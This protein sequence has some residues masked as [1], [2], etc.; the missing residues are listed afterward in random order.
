MDHDDIVGSFLD[1]AVDDRVDVGPASNAIM[2]PA[3]PA[4]FT[5]N[6]P[7]IERTDELRRI[8]GSPELDEGSRWIVVRDGLVVAE[9][10]YPDLTGIACPSAGA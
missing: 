8:A 2:E 1:C 5:V 7:W 9:V 6:L 3:P 10:D 4:Y